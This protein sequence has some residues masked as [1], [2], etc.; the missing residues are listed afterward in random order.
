ML[1]KVSERATR[2]VDRLTKRYYTNGLENA[3]VDSQ[4]GCKKGAP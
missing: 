1:R 2:R 4:E 3:T